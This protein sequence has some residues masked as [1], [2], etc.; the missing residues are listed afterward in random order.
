[1][2]NNRTVFRMFLFVFYFPTIRF[3]NSS[4]CHILFGNRI[5]E[6]VNFRA[7]AC[8]S[9]Y[10]PDQFPAISHPMH[11]LPKP[12]A[13]FR[14]GGLQCMKPNDSDETGRFTTTCDQMNVSQLR[15]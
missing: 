6:I 5:Y 11:V 13:E 4:T 15:E 7:F 14:C 9:C 1:M 2:I 12:N 3:G 10:R 8:P